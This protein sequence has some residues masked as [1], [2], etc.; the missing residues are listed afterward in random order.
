MGMSSSQMLQNG[1]T[2]QLPESPKK[3]QV[4]KMTLIEDVSLVNQRLLT[5]AITPPVTIKN[6]FKPVEKCSSSPLMKREEVNNGKNKGGK[7]KGKGKSGGVRS[8]F[9]DKKS[10]SSHSNND[11]GDF[12]VESGEKLCNGTSGEINGAT[13]FAISDDSNSCNAEKLAP[14]NSA[15]VTEN[16]T[17]SSTVGESNAAFTNSSGSGLLT[18][19]RSSS[20]GSINSLTGSTSKKRTNSSLSFKN[21]PPNKKSKQGNIMSSFA[22]Q[23]TIKEDKDEKQ[24]ICPICNIKFPVGTLNVKV[25]E[26]VDNCL[27]E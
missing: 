10:V 6:F 16:S 7:V 11:C 12:Q 19:K 22:K 13:V 18:V 23:K 20:S 25:N 2:I 15:K 3:D 1:L 24:L 26:H 14:D 17:S 21:A 4:R 27:I 5:K 8:L 9:G